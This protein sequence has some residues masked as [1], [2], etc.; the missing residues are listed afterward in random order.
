MAQT[1]NIESSHIPVVDLSSTTA[2]QELL[3]AAAN[4]GFIFIKYTDAI[5]LSPKDVD[6][7]F[8]IVS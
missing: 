5:G 6:N 1:S 2:P 4:N 7:I 3:E 8:E